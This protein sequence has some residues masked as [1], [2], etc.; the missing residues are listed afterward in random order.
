[1]RGRRL[2]ALIIKESLQ[3]TRDPSAILISF[4]LPVLL[5]FLYAYGVSLDLEHVPIGLVLEDTSP[6]AISFSRSLVDS[7]YFDVRIGRTRQEMVRALERGSIRGFVV[8]PSYFTQ[9]RNREVGIAPIQVIADGSETNTASF[10]KNYVGGA[11]QNWLQQERVSSDL[12]GL[13]LIGVETRFWYNEQLESRNFLLPG[14]LG[15]IMTLIGILL[16]ALV[17]AREWERGTMEAMMSTPIGILELMIGK[18]IPY[19]FLGLLSMAI[20]FLI[21]VGGFQIPFRGSVSI[22]FLVTVAFLFCA[23]SLG[24]MISTLSKNQLVA[25]QVSVIA[26]FLPAYILSG[27]LFEISSMPLWTQGLTYLMPA[28]YF[29]T[30][31]Q[32]L[33]L[34]GNV[35]KLILLNIAPMIVIGFV[36][37]LITA[38]K[39]VKRLD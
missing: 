32:T 9:F 30:T 36:L 1:M 3:I 10:V 13:P 24:L 35:W 11:F 18:I 5:I 37:L 31:L 26:G 2:R 34:V 29:V 28:R 14:S 12:K 38:C 6:D 19:F 20:C 4:V 33:F 39:T 16:T 27:F 15:I 25:F 21:T 8:V 22:L 23:L 17:V 7:R